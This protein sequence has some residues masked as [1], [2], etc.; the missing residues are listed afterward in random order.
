[1][2]STSEPP[3]PLRRFDPLDWPGDTPAERHAA[4][5]DARERHAEAYG[6]PGGVVGW[7]AAQIE[8]AAQTPDEPW[9]GS[10]V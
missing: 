1:V 2:S 10:G 8:A 9:D 6:W 4:W 5:C 7:G 3:E